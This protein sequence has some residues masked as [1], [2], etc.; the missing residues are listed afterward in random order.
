[1]ILLMNIGDFQNLDLSHCNVHS[2][3]KDYFLQDTTKK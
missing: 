3:N 1:M 2:W